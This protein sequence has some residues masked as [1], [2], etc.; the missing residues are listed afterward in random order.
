[1]ERQAGGRFVG[2]RGAGDRSAFE[3]CHHVL[4]HGREFSHVSARHGLGRR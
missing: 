1:M 4:A 2:V 3:L